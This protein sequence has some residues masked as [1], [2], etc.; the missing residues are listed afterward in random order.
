MKRSAHSPL[1]VLSEQDPSTGIYQDVRREEAEWEFLNFQ[2]RRMQKGEHWTHN[3]GDNEYIAFASID[4]VTLFT[5]NCATNG[6]GI[7]SNS[8]LFR[9]AT[10]L[11]PHEKTALH[12]LLR[13]CAK[14]NWEMFLG[15]FVKYKMP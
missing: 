11:K 10:S 7:F 4:G 13:G 5:V 8:I 9:N 15:D 14:Q 3:T 1:L 6:Y 2:A 12:N